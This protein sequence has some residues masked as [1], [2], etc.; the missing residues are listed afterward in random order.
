MAHSCRTG[1][2]SS[3]PEGPGKSISIGV[4]TIVPVPRQAMRKLVVNLLF[5]LSAIVGAVSLHRFV[6]LE[7]A[8]VFRIIL[9]RGPL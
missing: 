1:R 7:F 6:C 2:R 4:S 8:R 5:G 3:E 9:V